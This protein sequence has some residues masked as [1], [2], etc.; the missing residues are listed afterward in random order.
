[1]VQIIADEKF[2]D[3]SRVAHPRRENVLRAFWINPGHICNYVE[4]V[5]IVIRPKNLQGDPCFCSYFWTRHPTFLVVALKHQIVQ[6]PR[7]A[8]AP[9]PGINQVTQYLLAHQPSARDPAL[10]LGFLG[11]VRKRIRGWCEIV[12]KIIHSRRHQPTSA[13]VHPPRDVKAVSSLSLR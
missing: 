7:N 9:P 3:R 4:Q 5:Q 11:G 6:Q 12:K 13:M 10:L 1:M 8:T 2:P